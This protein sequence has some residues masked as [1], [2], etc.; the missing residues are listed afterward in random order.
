MLFSKFHSLP[1]RQEQRW[2]QLQ[3]LQLLLRLAW[4][5]GTARC[6]H[7]LWMHYDLWVSSTRFHP[8]FFTR[9]DDSPWCLVFNWVKPWRRCKE[10]HLKVYRTWCACLAI[11]RF[12]KM[13]L[14]QN[15]FLIENPTQMD[16]NWGYY[17]GPITHQNLWRFSPHRTWLNF[18]WPVLLAL[19]KEWAL[20][21]LEAYWSVP[22][23]PN[24]GKTVRFYHFHHS[25]AWGD[26]S[27]W[28]YR[29]EEVSQL[30]H[31]PNG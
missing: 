2:Q 8:W 13:G 22:R 17:M 9:D 15:V 4:L 12:R 7:F 29:K 28:L 27:P 11:W 26:I 14:P 16:D 18:L 20:G 25:P 10:I 3:Q 24:S 21:I 30:W 1:A 31:P 6:W 5:C 23:R 19:R